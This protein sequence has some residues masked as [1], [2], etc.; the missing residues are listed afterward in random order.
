M[1]ETIKSIWERLGCYSNSFDTKDLCSVENAQ[2]QVA[3]AIRQALGDDAFDAWLENVEILADKAG[4]VELAAPD[5]HTFNVLQ[6]RFSEKI[7]DT[8]HRMF[9]PAAS[10]KI[11]S[12][13]KS[14]RARLIAIDPFMYNLNP[15]YTFDNFIVGPSNRLAQAAAMAVAR[16]PGKAYNPLFIHSS[17]GLGKTHLVQAIC[18]AVFTQDPSAKLNYLSCET[19]VNDFIHAVELGDLTTF[20]LTYRKLNAIIIDDIQFLS[21]KERTQEEFFHTFNTLYNAGKQI[22][23]TSDSPPQEMSDLEDRLLSRFKWGLV[24]PIEPP[25]YETRVA[26]IRRK[27]RI[28]GFSIPDD[29]TEF[30]ARNLNTNIRE[31]EGAII[32]LS[33][34]AALT[35]RAID[36][37]L[38]VETF[39]IKDT[40]AHSISMDNILNVVI[41]RFGVKL[42]ELQSKKRTKAIVLPRQLCMYLARKL[43]AHSLEEIGGFFGGRD[44]S[45]VLYA[46]QKIA[47][48]IKTNNRLTSIVHDILAELDT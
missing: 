7:S 40:P 23:L 8:V 37:E 12:Q 26:I 20:R 11:T 41:K 44:H 1:V 28:R 3:E 16:S 46:A 6:A 2:L 42:S 47:S 15:Q 32:K 25:E 21:K 17:V 35:G 22:V 48:E 38:A 5:I 13:K 39:G 29:V 31:L 19:F 9:G 18:H 36:M 4:N 33:G 34:Y 45:T 27:A 24:V 30:M 10:V 14:V 43:T